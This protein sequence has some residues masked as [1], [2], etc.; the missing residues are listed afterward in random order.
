MSFLCL[1]TCM[2]AYTWSIS[3]DA[4]GQASLRRCH[5]KVKKCEIH[6]CIYTI[7]IITALP[8]ISVFYAV[9]MGEP[10]FIFLNMK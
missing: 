7:N 1:R 6:L 3:P 5:F 4:S 2:C 8:V 10:F 9:E